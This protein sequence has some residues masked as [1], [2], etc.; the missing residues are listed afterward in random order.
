MIGQSGQTPDFG[1]GTSTSLCAAGYR[2]GRG[3]L[4]LSPARASPDDQ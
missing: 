1:I 3:C 4:M 2:C